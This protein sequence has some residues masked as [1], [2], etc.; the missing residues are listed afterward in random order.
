MSLT[1]CY[2]YTAQ[3]APGIPGG[4]Q[5]GHQSKAIHPLRWDVHVHLVEVKYC[6]DTRP[7]QQPA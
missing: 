2:L 7:E 1:R 4:M 3:Y 6:D 5:K